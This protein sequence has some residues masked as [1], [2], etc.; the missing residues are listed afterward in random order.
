M[1]ETEPELDQVLKDKLSR[2]FHLFDDTYVLDAFRWMLTEEGITHEI[3]VQAAEWLL[4]KNSD[5][6]NNM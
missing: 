3:Y 4:W 5:L 1:D 6:L 2:M